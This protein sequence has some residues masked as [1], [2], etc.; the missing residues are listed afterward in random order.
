MCRLTPRKMS[1][2][3]TVARSPEPT[4]FTVWTFDQ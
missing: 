4:P 2:Q 1:G 3:A